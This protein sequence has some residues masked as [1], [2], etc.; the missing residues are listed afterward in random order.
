MS[1]SSA[2]A[3]GSELTGDFTVITW[4]LDCFGPAW[5][6]DSTS[7]P[8]RAEVWDLAEAPCEVRGSCS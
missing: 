3:A 8:S 1:G 4:Q 6:A 5:A 2:L 7:F